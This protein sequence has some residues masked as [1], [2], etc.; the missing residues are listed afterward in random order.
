MSIGVFSTLQE[1]NQQKMILEHNN[2]HPELIRYIIYDD[3]GMSV[4]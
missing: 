1:A 4:E 3:G 2:K